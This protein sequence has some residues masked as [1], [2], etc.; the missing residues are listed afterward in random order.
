M[1]PLMVKT[2]IDVVVVVVVVADDGDDV[3]MVGVV[4]DAP[5]GSAA[6]KCWT[7]WPDAC[8]T[9]A[10]CPGRRRR[11]PRSGRASAAARRNTSSASPAACS[12]R[13]AGPCTPQIKIKL[14]ILIK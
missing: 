7:P 13:T 2:T 6:R 5:G 1:D 14:F 4:A 12:A 3:M 8:W 10:C 11:F 9:H